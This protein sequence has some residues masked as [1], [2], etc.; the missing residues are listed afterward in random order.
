MNTPSAIVSQQCNCGRTGEHLHYS[1]SHDLLVKSGPVFLL[2]AE[3]ISFMQGAV[4]GSTTLYLE[5]WEIQRYEI[6]V[7][8][9]AELTAPYEYLNRLVIAIELTTLLLVV[10]AVATLHSIKNRSMHM[11]AIVGATALFVGGMITKGYYIS[12]TDAAL[13]R[14][15]SLVDPFV[16]ETALEIEQRFLRAYGFWGSAA[17]DAINAIFSLASLV[18]LVAA[19][20]TSRHFRV[21]QG[22]PTPEV[23]ALGQPE[24]PQATTETLRERRFCESCGSQMPVLAAI[25]PTCGHRSSTEPLVPQPRPTKFCRYCRATILRESKF[26]EEC[27]KKLA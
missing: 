11:V 5:N 9:M 18:F 3:G 2:L 10:V 26:C 20:I 8:K 24:I 15:P 12:A 16:L 13:T 4:K 19:L 21:W 14:L 6:V 27:G 1:G 23:T 25:C 7:R 17:P 22:A